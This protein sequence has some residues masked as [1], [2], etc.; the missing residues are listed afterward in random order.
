M[1]QNNVTQQQNIESVD[2]SLTYCLRNSWQKLW[3]YFLEMLLILIISFLI[4]L[5]EVGLYVDS[6]KDIVSNVISINLILVNVRGFGAYV[7]FA[8]AYIV[9]FSNPVKY[10]VQYAFLKVSRDEKVEVMDMF[11]FTKNFWNTVFAYL[12]TDIIIVVGCL[13][14]LVPGII[15]AC[16]LAFVSYLVVEKKMDAVSAIKESWRMTKGHSYTVFVIGLLAIFIYIGGFLLCGVGIILSTMW[17]KLAFA[18]L[19]HSVSLLETKQT[20]AAEA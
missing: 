12:L 9:L 4:S 11:L 18:S 14:C 2:T 15:L 8:V 6:L 3:K 1:N 10:G 5:P 20:P 17:V 19:Y 7:V 16:K 13:F